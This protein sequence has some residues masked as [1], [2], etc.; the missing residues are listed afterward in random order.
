MYTFLLTG[1]IKPSVRMTR[2]GQYV[3]PQAQEYKASQSAIAWQYK[4]QMREQSWSMLPARTPLKISILIE[5]PER[6]HCSDADNQVKAIVDAAQG[7]V[8][9]NDLWI[10]EIRAARRLG[11]EHRVVVVI[12]VLA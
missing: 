6:L 1:K 9:Q 2:L 10:D 4:A 12:G 7:I 11:K 8:F 5:M 3:D